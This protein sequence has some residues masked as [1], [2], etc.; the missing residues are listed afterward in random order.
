MLMK[1][2]ECPDCV[3]FINENKHHLHFAV[4][5][6]AQ[7]YKRSMTE[8]L[9]EFISIYHNNGHDDSKFSELEELEI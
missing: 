6:V 8:L 5:Y 9:L 1:V 4:R 3:D 2:K 7:K